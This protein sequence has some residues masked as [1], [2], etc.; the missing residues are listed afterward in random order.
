LLGKRVLSDVGEGLMRYYKQFDKRKYLSIIPLVLSVVCLSFVISE[1]GLDSRIILFLCG[2]V[3]I[4]GGW[5]IRK[6]QR[7]YLEIDDEK[8]IH[9]GFRNWTIRKSDVTR[10]EKGRKGWFNDN[11]L[12]LRVFADKAKFVVDDGFLTDEE[13][14][15][16]LEKVIGSH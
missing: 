6:G 15:Q 2:V 14:V 8:I 11:E 7:H 10:V 4:M 1:T 3:F 13:H 9:R 12:Y 16:E 5:I